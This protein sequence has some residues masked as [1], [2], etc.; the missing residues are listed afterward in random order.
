[1]G[2]VC[3]A[4]AVVA[5][6]AAAAIAFFVPEGALTRTM[7]VSNGYGAKMACSVVFVAG[8]TLESAI[9]A[10]LTFPPIRFVSSLEVEPATKCV[11]ARSRIT[12]DE[13][14]ACWVSQR[15]GCVLQH[16][17]GLFDA[18]APPSE[19]DGGAF[20]ADALFPRG[21]AAD[22]AGVAAARAGLNMSRIDD[23]VSA[24]FADSRLHAR[25]FLLV[26]GGHVVYEQYGD[27][28]GAS[29]PLLGWS[30]TKSWINTLLGIRALDQGRSAAEALA[31]QVPLAGGAVS[32]ES[33]LRMS[34]GLDF[35][36]EYFPLG[37]APKMLFLQQS[38]LLGERGF[39]HSP[40]AAEPFRCFQYSSHS[41]NVLS[42]F[43]RSSF[44][45]LRDYLVF[46]TERMFHRLGMRSAV[47][48]PSPEGVF[49]G[50]SFGWAT[51]RDWARWGL[52]FLGDGVSP[53]T[54]ERML[55][56]GTEA[57]AARFGGSGIWRLSGVSGGS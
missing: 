13:R 11:V 52:L 42:A 44:D 6:A 36:E 40:S 41:T 39:R 34:D 53:S 21:D 7:Q 26:R 54:G 17:D 55:P 47:M 35:D 14:R 25:A 9:V 23:A 57:L 38:L 16:D 5:V 27:G 24:H 37:D 56:E 10:E 46:P 2:R 49:V 48:E 32:V 43:L 18:G 29:T 51:A 3:N 8:R 4:V 19:D 12:R 28:C 1:M 31:D 22:A 15:L 20:D 33:L 45:S 30:M 50:S